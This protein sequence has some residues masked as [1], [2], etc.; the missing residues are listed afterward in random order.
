M[1]SINDEAFILPFL[2]IN[3]LDFLYS[4][5]WHDVVFKYNLKRFKIHHA[6]ISID[7]YQFKLQIFPVCLQYMLIPD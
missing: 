7:I 2:Q 1:S 4:L 3:L 5:K 6:T